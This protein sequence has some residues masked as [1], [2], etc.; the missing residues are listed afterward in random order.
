MSAPLARRRQ[1]WGRYPP[2]RACG[3]SPPRFPRAPGACARSTGDWCSR[4]TSARVVVEPPVTSWPSSSGARP[5]AVSVVRTSR[6]WRLPRGSAWIASRAAARPRRR[7]RSPSPFAV[8]EW[9]RSNR[10]FLPRWLP[11]PAREAMRPRRTSSDGYLSDGRVATAVSRRKVD[12]EGRLV[13]ITSYLPEVSFHVQ[14]KPLQLPR[15]RGR[16]ER[17]DGIDNQRSH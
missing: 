15:R 2:G 7:R 9:G 5:L 13:Q 1:R 8:H 16:Q 17:S 4:E 10:G 11:A 14:E 3:A 6:P 12:A